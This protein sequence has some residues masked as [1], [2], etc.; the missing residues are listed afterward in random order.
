MRLVAFRLVHGLEELKPVY[1]NPKHV[2]SLEPGDKEQKTSI[3][4]F[5]NRGSMLVVG[6]IYHLVAHLTSR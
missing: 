4:S 3:L 1:V 5:S 6:D 2:V